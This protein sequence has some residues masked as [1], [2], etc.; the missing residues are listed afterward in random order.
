MMCDQKWKEDDYSVSI[1][2]GCIP[3]P[4]AD[5]VRSPKK[6]FRNLL[7]STFPA[8]DP[9][10]LRLSFGSHALSSLAVAQR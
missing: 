4:R 2:C 3:G 9:I 1:K 10:N 7:R 5:S 8:V 6:D